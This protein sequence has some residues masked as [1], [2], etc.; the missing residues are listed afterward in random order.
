MAGKGPRSYRRALRER[1]GGGGARRLTI[2][3]WNDA[4]PAAAGQPAGE[5]A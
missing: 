5:Q 3:T 2:D 1:G 4:P